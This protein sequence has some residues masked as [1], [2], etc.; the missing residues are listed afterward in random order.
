MLALCW[1]ASINICTGIVADL[2]VTQKNHRVID[3]KEALGD[4]GLWSG[5]QSYLTSGREKTG[6]SVQDRMRYWLQQPQIPKA[7]DRSRHHEQLN[8]KYFLFDIDIGGLN[9]I[10]LG[11]EAA[12]IIAYETGRTLVIPPKMPFYLIDWGAPPFQPPEPDSKSQ[13]SDFLNMHQLA[14]GLHVVTFD[15][16]RQQNNFPAHLSDIDVLKSL[17]D[18]SDAVTITEDIC[19][20]QTY[21]T[22][23]EN[24]L[25]V[26]N[27]NKD[28]SVGRLFG[29]TD[30]QELGDVHLTSREQIDSDAHVSLLRNHFVWHEEVFEL[31]GPIIEQLGMFQYNALHYRFGD[32]QFTE[33]KQSPSS[34]AEKYFDT[35]LGRELFQ[36]SV[37]YISTDTLSDDVMQA[38]QTLGI[39]TMWSKDFFEN[40]DSPIAHLL[41]RKGPVRVNQ[42]KGPVEQVVCAFAKIFVGT[43][44]STFTGYINRLRINADAPQNGPDTL[45]YHT[46]RLTE[47][48]VKS[49]QTR[50]Q[51][52][53]QQPV[54]YVQLR[55][56]LVKDNNYGRKVWLAIA[57]VPAL[58]WAAT[59]AQ[60]VWLICTCYV[61]ASV[62]MNILNKVAAV[63]FSATFLLVILQMIAADIIVTA[64][65]FPK[66]K[67][68]R[69]QDLLKW[70]AV[71]LFFAG[72]L[73]TSL[74]S[75]K[76]ASLT[77][78]LIIRNILPIISFAAEKL[79][80]NLP[81][82]VPI[83]MV[84]SLL[85]TL[86]G[87]VMYGWA[88][89]SI[90]SFGKMMILVNCLFTL[91]DRLLQTQ[92]LKRTPDFSISIPLCMVLNNT[93][94]IIPLVALA[95][96]TGEMHT[97]GFVLQNAGPT[98]WFWVVMSGCGACLG[99]IGL[100]AQKILSGT[101]ILVIQ[102]FN[103]ILIIIMGAELF[104]EK[105]SF[106]SCVGCVVSLAGCFWYGH[107]RLPSEVSS[108]KSPPQEVLPISAKKS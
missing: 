66:M 16:F 69:Y 37:L 99:Y 47:D 68:G 102:N 46:E 40:S 39:K 100:K 107:L 71:P 86:A 30:W 15:E 25:Y 59:T 62:A 93:M 91:A 53:P 76:E 51:A 85:V 1:W 14:D 60:N 64:I 54:S 108:F 104:G 49:I 26:N 92:L 32:L 13:M 80:F 61:T 9:N 89:V 31:A 84:V 83:A 11:W 8:G 90:S 97:W 23:D 67:C 43:K 105:F 57:I 21:S 77:A 44:L 52:H 27:P 45:L 98:G 55:H 18:R 3:T 95:C 20:L 48:M 101:T 63:A 34:I 74:W 4:H 70:S 36:N 87:S 17:A 103:K 2:A 12:G 58:L 50:M 41:E 22:H 96:A 73:A 24:M 56:G 88:D 10:R 7:G 79:L 6:A 28:A 5:V 42:L 38:F 106:L 82:Q 78:I 35:E 33:S 29:C 72:M 94:G 65:E 75:F 19:D 81:P